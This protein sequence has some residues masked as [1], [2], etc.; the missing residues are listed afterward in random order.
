MGNHIVAPLTHSTSN[1]HQ[2]T[3]IHPPPSIQFPN[4]STSFTCPKLST[5]SKTSQNRFSWTLNP[6]LRLHLKSQT[7]PRISQPDNNPGIHLT[8]PIHLHWTGSQPVHLVHHPCHGCNSLQSS[9]FPQP[10]PES[11]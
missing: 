10:F 9:Q 5:T 2:T 3:F 1:L 11:G 7:K 6:D 8:H 4:E